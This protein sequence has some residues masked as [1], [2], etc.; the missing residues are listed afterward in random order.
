MLK[1]SIKDSKLKAPKINFPL[2]N[3]TI[4]EIRKFLH[5]SIADEYC[6]KHVHWLPG[7][8]KQNRRNQRIQNRRKSIGNCKLNE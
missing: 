5:P 8:L 4:G 6:P 7:N 2:A 3:A 1:A